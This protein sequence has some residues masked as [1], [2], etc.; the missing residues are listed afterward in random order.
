MLSA[1][2]RQV[3][4]FAFGT[5]A[6]G[7]KAFLTPVAFGAAAMIV[8]RDG[9]VAFA[10][11]S[12]R[13]MLSFPGGGI[14]R[15]EPPAHA[16]LRELDEELGSVR[17]DPPVLFGLYTQRSLLATHVIALYR[18]MNSNVEFRPSWEVRELM[19]ADPANPPANI[20]MG[21]VRRLAEHLGKAPISPY[22]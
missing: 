21:T 2:T 20:T 16:V 18:L 22:W 12:Y 4:Q 10:R 1:L 15:G 3:G 6:L 11:H 9:R 17:S 19:F 7:A 13:P 14:K 5:L 8:D